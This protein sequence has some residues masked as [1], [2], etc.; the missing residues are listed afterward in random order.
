MENYRDYIEPISRKYPTCNIVKDPF[1]NLVGK[2]LGLPNVSR[3]WE[4]NGYY[5]YRLTFDYKEH[6][7]SLPL[8]LFSWDKDAVPRQVVFKTGENVPTC[9]EHLSFQGYTLFISDSIWHDKNVF[10]RPYTTLEQ[11]LINLDL[12]A[13]S[14]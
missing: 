10:W 5:G 12:N 2:C 4:F 9:L 13:A 11:T 7:M 1:V 6:P 8:V 14:N 3:W